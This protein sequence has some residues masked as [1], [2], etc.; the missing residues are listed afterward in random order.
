[1]NDTPRITE[2]TGYS[3]L[4]SAPGEQ[5]R[6]GHFL[7]SYMDDCQSRFQ[8]WFEEFFPV[9]REAKIH[10]KYVTM[11]VEE[12]RRI[13]DELSRLRTM[14]AEYSDD[15]DDWSDY[16]SIFGRNPEPWREPLGALRLTLAGDADK[17]DVVRAQHE[18][19][20]LTRVLN[21]ADG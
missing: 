1:M 18:I 5:P 16:R 3:A 9:G 14:E 2:F 13:T 17:V 15:E 6:W 21:G 11:L 4:T 19:E 20:W 7:A 10:G 8:K 12:W